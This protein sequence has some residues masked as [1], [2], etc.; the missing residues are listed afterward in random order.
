[1]ILLK[2]S[3]E[4]FCDLL[5]EGRSFKAHE[6]VEGLPPNS[7]VIHTEIDSSTGLMQFV[8]DCHDGDGVIH[9]GKVVIENTTITFLGNN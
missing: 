2:M 6:V 1:M 4:F 3:S 8:I 5:T 7:Q 9:E